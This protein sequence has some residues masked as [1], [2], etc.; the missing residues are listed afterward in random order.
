MAPPLPR[1]CGADCWNSVRS[2]VARIADYFAADPVRVSAL[3]RLPLI[4]L[5]GFLVWLWEVDSWL[6][7]VYAAILGAYAVAAVLWALVVF[8]GPVPWWG[9]WLSTGVD[10]GDRKSVV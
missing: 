9:G 7:G 5:M 1:R 6:P 8:R 10:A 2:S 3:L 4:V